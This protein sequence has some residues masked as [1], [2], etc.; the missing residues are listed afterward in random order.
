MIHDHR[1]LYNHWICGC[2]DPGVIT[3]QPF[4][5]RPPSADRELLESIHRTDPGRSWCSIQRCVCT[6]LNAHFHRLVDRS[7]AQSTISPSCLYTPLCGHDW[8]FFPL[9]R[10]CSGPHGACVIA[11]DEYLLALPQQCCGLQQQ[12]FYF[13]P[14]NP[15]TCL[16]YL[17]SMSG[18]ERQ[19]PYE[20]LLIA[21]HSFQ[22]ASN[23]RWEYGWGGGVNG[24]GEDGWSRHG[25]VCPCAGF[26]T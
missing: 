8:Q 16:L 12:T 4:G 13:S 6:I 9:K 15:P 1:N 10:G 11:L 17:H 20:T 24:A 18:P 7:F 25:R 14:L 5:P 3:P 21:S 22:A 23:G 2:C 19:K 26:Q